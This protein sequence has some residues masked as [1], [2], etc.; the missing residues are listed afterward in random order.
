MNTKTLNKHKARL[1]GKL[2]TKNEIGAVIKGLNAER[3]SKHGASEPLAMEKGMS[4]FIDSIA[5]HEDAEYLPDSNSYATPITFHKPI[6]ITEDQSDIGITWLKAYCFG[7]RGPRKQPAFNSNDLQ[8][9]KTFKRFL[10]VGILLVESE[11]GSK[12][13]LPIYRTI[14]ASNQSFDYSPIHWGVPIVSKR[15]FRLRVVA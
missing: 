11:Y 3:F 6:K 10:F 14:G 9:I 12:Y 7:V 8:V 15:S 4:T 5:E 1:T 2:M 13:Y